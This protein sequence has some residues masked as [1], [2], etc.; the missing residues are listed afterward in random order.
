MQHNRFKASC[1]EQRGCTPSHMHNGVVHP[2]QN[3]QQHQPQLPSPCVFRPLSF[4]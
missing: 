3:Y 4:L 2:S 1:E